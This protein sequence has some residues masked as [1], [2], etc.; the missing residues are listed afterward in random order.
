M[1]HLSTFIHS[2]DF[3][4]ARPL[5]GWIKDMPRPLTASTLA[6]PGKDYATYLADAREVT[7]PDAGKEITG[8]VTFSLPSG[9]YPVRLCA[10]ATG[11]ASPAIAVSGD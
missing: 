10:P 6:V 3:I 8:K 4:H 1:K 2:L 9:T 7:D 5:P 11:A